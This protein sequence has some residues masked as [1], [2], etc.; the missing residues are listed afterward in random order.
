VQL[1]ATVLKTH[2]GDEVLIPNAEVYTTTVTNVSRYDLH[3]HDIAISLP[4]QADPLRAS[5]SITQALGEIAGIAASPA[6]AVVAVGFDAQAV[7]LEVRFWIDERASDTDAVTTAVVAAIHKAI[8]EPGR[9]G[10]KGEGEKG[11]K[12]EGEKG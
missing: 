11:R 6:P 3:R 9:E 10:R 2:N 12:G 5:A 1:R 8:A 4:P 7:K